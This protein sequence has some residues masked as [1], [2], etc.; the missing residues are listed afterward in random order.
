[1]GQQLEKVYSAEKGE[2][3]STF[4]DRRFSKLGIDIYPSYLQDK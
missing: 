4:H 2:L 3:G 1:M